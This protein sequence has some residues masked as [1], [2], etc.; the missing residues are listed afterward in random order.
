M[1][2]LQM[3]PSPGAKTNMAPENRDMEG[4]FLLET[5]WKPSFLGVHVSFWG[6]KPVVI[7]ENPRNY[8][9]NISDSYNPTWDR[10]ASSVN[11]TGPK[12]KMRYKQNR[13]GNS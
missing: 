2:P 12:L 10:N 13:N 11:P 3:I 7:R 5:F 8:T 1:S 6:L 9:T 4:R